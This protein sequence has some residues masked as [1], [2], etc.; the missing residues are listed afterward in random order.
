VAAGGFLGSFRTRNDSVAPCYGK[1]I[2]LAKQLT[3]QGSPATPAPVAPRLRD[4]C[5]GI[6][7]SRACRANALPTGGASSG[8]DNHRQLFLPLA[9]AVADPQTAATATRCSALSVRKPAVA[10]LLGP[11]VVLV[12]YVVVFL[13]CHRRRDVLDSSDAGG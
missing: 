1:S 7:K 3:V 6:R 8:H 13:R 9:S 4:I 10:I 11:L 2:S 5:T 12:S